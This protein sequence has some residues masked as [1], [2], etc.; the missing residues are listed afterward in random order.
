MKIAKENRMNKWIAFILAVAI[1]IPVMAVDM[2]ETKTNRNKEGRTVAE[3][4]VQTAG[5]NVLGDLAP[6]FAHY[7]DDILFGEVWNKQDVLDLR[8]RSMITVAGLMGLGITDNSLKYHI[9]NAKN[10]GV[11][12]AEMVDEITQLAFYLGWP[13]AWAV[14]PM[15]KEVYEEDVPGAKPLAETKTASMEKQTAGRRV[16]G[17]LAPEFARYNDDILFGEVWARNK[18]LSPHDRS[19]IT[20]AGLMGANMM[21]SAFHAHLQMGKAHGMTKEEVVDEITQL[22]FYT[23]WPKAWAAFG[24][25]K[26]VYAVEK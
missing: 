12:K 9:G 24:M 3:K 6:E 14:F 19:M 11:T 7:N 13:K 4:V 15:V 23:G 18:V 17:E 26:E 22:A 16:L 8:Q 25:V 2:Q 5:R 21:G 20:I 10:H 1:G